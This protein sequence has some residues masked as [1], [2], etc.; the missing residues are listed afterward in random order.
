MASQYPEDLTPFKTEEQTINSIF[1]E[2]IKVATD[3][4]YQLIAHL[5]IIKQEFLKKESIRHKQLKDLEEIIAS[6]RLASIHQNEILKYQQDQIDQTLAKIQEYEQPTPLPILSVETEGL[7]SI[8]KQLGRLGQL[9]TVQNMPLPYSNKTTPVRCY[10]KRDGKK[11]ELNSPVGI[12]IYG[13]D[14]YAVDTGNKRIQILS[15]ADECMG[16]LGKGLL[17]KPHGISVTDKWVFVSDWGL[18]A[19]VKFSKT[20][21]KFIRKSIEGKLNYPTGLTTDTDGDVLVADFWKH[22]V[23]VFSSDLKILREIGKDKLKQPQDVKIHKTNIFVADENIYNNLH[24]FSKSGDFLKSFIKLESGI[25]YKFV[26]FDSLN[27]ILISDCK[28]NSVKIFNQEG[29]LIYKIKCRR[30]TGIFVKD[31]YDIIC[32][33]HSDNVVYLY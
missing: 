24:I 22:M 32:A 13:E 10:G 33:S 3:R 2:V 4:R 20:N 14:I 17:S 8:L 19:V 31:N 27:N 15:E 1:E 29:Q 26:S 7:D 6:L 25:G 5:S 23:I 16:E 21:R 30:S 11:G 9:G 12:D 18:Q 28:D